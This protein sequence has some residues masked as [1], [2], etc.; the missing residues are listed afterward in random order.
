MHNH[1]QHNSFTTTILNY[2]III[3]L[4]RSITIFILPKYY[5]FYVLPCTYTHN[6][7]Q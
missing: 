5:Q 1:V 3:V 6:Y 2:V 4:L 7:V